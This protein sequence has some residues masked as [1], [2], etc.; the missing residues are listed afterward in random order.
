MSKEPEIISQNSSQSVLK[1]H[2]HQYGQTLLDL[3]FLNIDE[4]TIE[5]TTVVKDGTTYSYGNEEQYKRFSVDKDSLRLQEESVFVGRDINYIYDPEDGDPFA[6][7]S[8]ITSVSFKY[9]SNGTEKEHTVIIDE[10]IDDIDRSG[11]F[12]EN[13]YTI[14][15]YGKEITKL[16]D[17]TKTLILDNT[18]YVIKDLSTKMSWKGTMDF[19]LNVNTDSNKPTGVV[20]SL[21]HI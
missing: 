1:M 20:L 14:D 2:E 21:I 11:S 4:G 19:G 17:E 8:Y 12:A 13:K 6:T 15:I 18:E 7:S 3:T 9:K 5:F 16:S 10:I